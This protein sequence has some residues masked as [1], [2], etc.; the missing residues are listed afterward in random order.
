MAKRLTTRF[1][2]NAKR[3]P[4]KR[5]EIPDAGK[6]GL[7]LVIQPSGKRSWAVRYRF[8]GRPRKVTLEGFPSLGV[9]HKLAQAELDK[10]A[11]GRDPAVEK[12][13]AKSARRD[14][15]GS[16]AF[17][18]V[19]AQFIERHAKRNTRASSARE[20]ERI[21]NKEVLPKWGD[22]RIQEITK[23]H[24][25]DLLDG[26]VDRGGGLSANRTLAVVRKLFN[27]AV[28]R[29][30]I[31][32]SPVASIKA[33]LAE[34]SRD[35]VLSDDEIRW[36]WLAC[37]KVA[38]PFGSMAKLLL[39]T[40]QRRNEVAGMTFGELDLDKALWCIPGGRTKNDEAHEVPLSDAAFAIIESVPRIATS[41]GFVLTTRAEKHLRGY[42]QAKKAIDM[43][44][45]AVAREERGE[46]VK[47]PRWTF[48]DLRRTA[49]SGMARLRIALP[50]I[51]KALNHS[52]GSFAGI[53]GVYQHHHFADEKREALDAWASFVMSVVEGKPASNVVAIRA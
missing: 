10:V 8:N 53:V 5:R 41:K 47:I 44:M 46:D 24:V 45:F 23:R 16:D 28:Q 48:H 29:G 49:A 51:E 18:A 36:L 32:A 26:I 27:W 12:K 4:A 34:R 6:P 7:Y 40:G 43:A 3:D 33:P 35:R 21:L 20:T 25:L 15:T 50:V 14:D 11:E 9:A 38:Y 22:K 13:A 52:S 30:I 37:D 39:L 1:V 17:E 42:S 2:E 31:D 19:A